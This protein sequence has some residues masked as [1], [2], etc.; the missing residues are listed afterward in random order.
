[1]PSH[2]DH[3]LGPQSSLVHIWSKLDTYRERK[4]KFTI[5]ISQQKLYNEFFLFGILENSTYN[6]K[7][8][9]CIISAIKKASLNAFSNIKYF[10]ILSSKKN[11]QLSNTFT[12]L[13]DSLW[14]TFSPDQDCSPVSFKTKTPI[15]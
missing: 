2:P 6:W 7:L 12:I 9:Y 4:T 3:S 11:L 10:N 15:W 1:M 8:I 14:N 5:K 13:K